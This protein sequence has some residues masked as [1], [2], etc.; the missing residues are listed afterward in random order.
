MKVAEIKNG[1]NKGYLLQKHMPI[2]AEKF[3]KELIERSD[4][5]AQG[6]LAGVKEQK[7]ERLITR[8]KNYKMSQVQKAKNRTKDKDKDF[9]DK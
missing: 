6:F 7:K 5:Y 9:R 3:A 4:A 8:T 2:L 1:F